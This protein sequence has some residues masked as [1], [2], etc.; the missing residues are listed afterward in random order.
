MFIAMVVFGSAYFLGLRGLRHTGNPP[1]QIFQGT[2]G[3]AVMRALGKG[4][5]HPRIEQVPGLAE[6]LETKMDVFDPKDIPEKIDVGSPDPSYELLTTGQRYVYETVAL[7]WRLTGKIS[8]SHLIY[9]QALFLALTTLA[10]FAFLSVTLGLPWALVGAALIATSDI[11]IV[12][13]IGFRDSAKA[14]F[15]VGAAVALVSLLVRTVTARQ[16]LSLAALAGLLT[17]IGM[18][19]RPDQRAFVPFFILAVVLFFSMP[20][21]RPWIFKGALIAVFLV[22]AIA[23]GAPVIFGGGPNRGATIWHVFLLGLGDRFYQMLYLKPSLYSVTTFSDRFVYNLYFA[24]GEFIGKPLG[25]AYKEFSYVLD[26]PPGYGDVSR[27]HFFEVMNLLTADFATRALRTWQMV[28]EVFLEPRTRYPW[29]WVSWLASFFKPHVIGLSIL[30]ICALFARSSRFALLTLFS[31]VYWAGILSL[32]FDQRHFFHYEFFAW[33]LVLLGV[34]CV[35]RL[36]RA[37]FSRQYKLSGLAKGFVAVG[38]LFACVTLFNTGLRARQSDRVRQ[39]IED[40]L[41]APKSE[42]A[43]ERDEGNKDAAFFRS[44]GVHS[45]KKVVDVEFRYLLLEIAP[46]LP[47]TTETSAVATARYSSSHQGGDFSMPLR[48][49]PRAPTKFFFGVFRTRISDNEF[50][51]F[52]GIEIPAQLVEKL[53]LRLHVVDRLPSFP[54]LQT[55]A[56]PE[57]WRSRDLFVQFY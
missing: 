46:R 57:D 4:Y 38:V 56:L 55:I 28:V 25:T 1:L 16:A 9:L 24:Y 40:F 17:G 10:S 54:L 14:P 29:S 36:P 15:F 5:F 6:F 12:N 37:I 42:V 13:A 51:E 18:G 34:A 35:V 22:V 11:H 23:A 33:W 53:S 31:I 19:F 48:F 50:S 39:T 30:A 7:Y 8:W 45:D 26:I 49:D 41:V 32:Q 20:I 2:Y 43:L 44:R 27:T 52:S 47:V 3:P 21:R